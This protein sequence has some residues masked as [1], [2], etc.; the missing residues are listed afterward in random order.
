METS[1]SWYGESG[2][3]STQRWVEVKVVVAGRM[4][5]IALSIELASTIV[6]LKVRRI[7]PVVLRLASASRPQAT[8]NRS[9]LTVALSVNASGGRELSAG[10]LH[11]A[12]QTIEK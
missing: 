8:G 9:T 2:R 11:T 1:K 5:A 6:K 12:A 7:F 4:K 3:F 10:S